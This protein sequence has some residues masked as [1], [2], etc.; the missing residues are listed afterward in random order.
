MLG[1]GLT[2]GVI[3]V[4]GDRTWRRITTAITPLCMAGVLLS[5]SRGSI[6][7]LAAGWLAVGGLAVAQRGG[8]LCGVRRWLLVTALAAV[9]VTAL[10]SSLFFAR[11]AAPT[12]AVESRGAGSTESSVRY[13]ILTDRAALAVIGEHPWT[14]A[15]F[16][17]FFTAGSP[18]MPVNFTRSPYVHNGYL[19]AAE[20]GGLLLAVPVLT[21][22]A[23]AGWAAAR[24][25]GRSWRQLAGDWPR[26][27]C[28]AGA[29]G[30][31]AHA[32]I[33]MD[34]S[35]PG[36]VVLTVLLLGVAGGE[37]A[38]RTAA[39]ARLGCIAASLL[40][41]L[42]LTLG[43]G[44]A[45]GV[46]HWQQARRLERTDP[47]S[48]ATTAA[49]QFGV[50]RDPKV[51]AAVLTAAVPRSFAG[52]VTMPH[53]VVADSLARTARLAT[54]DGA[55]QMQRAQAYV[56]LG[57]PEEAVR[58]AAELAAE[59]S[60]NRPFLV[61]EYAEILAS[62][63]RHGEAV[64]RLAEALEDNAD[65][66]A[67]FR[68]HLVATLQRI[69]PGASAT[70]AWCAAAAVAASAERPPELAALALPAMPTTCPTAVP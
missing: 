13:R 12:A 19:Q 5:G 37:S 44:S 42:A 23:A 20:E 25:R 70:R 65:E 11:S 68:W 55:L 22:L 62:V 27:A 9:A 17:S 53:D 24:R 47:T 31:L 4:I 38:L 60:G 41:V 69:D 28:A 6:L 57:R 39:P 46:A 26:V 21:S 59:Q 58:L 2:A 10:T 3:A 43:V 49:R 32:A 34:W 61:S 18:H 48:Q 8:A 45:A 50:F 40:A 67:T 36:L 33:D 15:G 63:G 35:F 1:T 51:D 7:V 54:V 14:G 16:D 66:P 56:A 29:A 64:D 52:T 30:L